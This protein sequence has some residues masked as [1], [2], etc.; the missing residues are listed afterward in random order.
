MYLRASPASPYTRKV[1]IA[2]AIL[3]LDDK[4]EIVQTDTNDVES[5]LRRENPLGKIPALVDDGVAY[6]DSRVIAEYLDHIAGG[7]RLFPSEAK[8]RF[9]ALRLQ[10]LADGICD[11]ALL[12]VYE[13]RYRTPEQ[14]NPN[15]VKLQQGK[16]DRALAALEHAPPAKGP[17]PAIGEIATACALGYLDLRLGGVWRAAHPALVSWLDD[18]ASRHP[19]FAQTRVVA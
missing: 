19:T 1:R 7:N 4:I 2:A 12:I 13:G 11:A 18:F 6:F 10:A 5:P 8:A 3:K 16:I 15:W 9:A 17:N 14:H